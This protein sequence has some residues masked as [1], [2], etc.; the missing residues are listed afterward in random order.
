MIQTRAQAVKAVKE[1]QKK[2]GWKYGRIASKARVNRATITRMMEDDG[3]IPNEN[4]CN[5]LYAVL[6]MARAE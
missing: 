1:I 6:L 4:T 3:P 2:T 5:G